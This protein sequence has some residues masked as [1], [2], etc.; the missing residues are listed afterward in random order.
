M[1]NIFE[2]IDTE[3]SG[4]ES[5]SESSD[6]DSDS[7][8]NLN[9]AFPNHFLN[10]TKKEDYL[11]NRNK[12]FTPDLLTKYLVINKTTVSGENS[13]TINFDTDLRLDPM[14]NVIGFKLI[15]SVTKYVN[16]STSPSYVSVDLVINEIPH[17]A[18]KI[19]NSE[20]FII[21]KLPV[22]AAEDTLFSFIP[23]R[24]L[25]NYFYPISL[26]NLTFV[27]KPW[28]GVSY[29]DLSNEVWTCI[30]EFEVIILN[31]TNLLK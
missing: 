29:G 23:I 8:N 16:S 17:E 31:N 4:D 9:E 30:F 6:S 2:K 11:V 25:G 14:K 7:N 10:M 27:L 21:D 1:D 19:S 18:C 22:S 15:R 3:S 26:S 20:T 28:D 24:V 5:S 12:L 13:F